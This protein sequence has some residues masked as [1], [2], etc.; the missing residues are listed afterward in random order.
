[1]AR[2]LA[3]LAACLLIAGCGGAKLTESEQLT[4][5][6]AN[7]AAAYTVLDGSMYSETVDGVDRVIR[8]YREKPDAKYN[9]LTMREVLEDLASTLE[10]Y[11]PQLATRLDRALGR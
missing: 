1:M 7:E 11:R 5:A 10:G 3:L 9:E 8:I 4:V 2:L 6:E